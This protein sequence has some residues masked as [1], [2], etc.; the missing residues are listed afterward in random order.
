V[1]YRDVPRWADVTYRVVGG[2]VIGLVSGQLPTI[3]N[4]DTAPPIPTSVA[5]FPDSGA[6]IVWECTITYR[7]GNSS[8]SFWSVSNQYVRLELP[9]PP[10]GIVLPGVDGVLIFRYSDYTAILSNPPPCNE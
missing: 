9:F 4:R 6:V 5:F 3:Q 8:W 10:G 2:N 1:T 7:S